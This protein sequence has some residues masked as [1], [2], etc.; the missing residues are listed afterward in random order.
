MR[1]LCVTQTKATEIVRSTAFYIVSRL[2]ARV[3]EANKILLEYYIIV[4]CCITLLL[5]RQKNEFHE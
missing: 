1:N 2:G 3:Q 4:C 5:Y